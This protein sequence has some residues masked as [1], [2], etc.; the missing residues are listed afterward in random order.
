MKK[1]AP[2]SKTVA[3]FRK[4]NIECIKAVF[5]EFVFLCRSLDLSGPELIGTDGSKFRAMNSRKRCFNE[6]TRRGVEA[7]RGVDNVIPE[8]DGGELLD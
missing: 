4:D 7:S 3:D 2:D 8:G 6:K 5:K 1:L